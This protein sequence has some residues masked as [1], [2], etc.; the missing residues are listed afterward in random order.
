MSPELKQKT[1]TALICSNFGAVVVG[2]AII[3]II[4]AADY[5]YSLQLQLWPFCVSGACLDIAAALV[6]CRISLAIAT[7]VILSIV[8]SIAAPALNT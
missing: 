6:K 4:G 8:A 1:V 7:T 3:P 2:T 5:L